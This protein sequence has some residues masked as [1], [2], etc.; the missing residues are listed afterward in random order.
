MAENVLINKCFKSS[1]KC[2]SIFRN[3]KCNMTGD[4]MCLTLCLGRKGQT[5]GPLEAA[6][7]RPCRAAWIYKG[8]DLG[9]KGKFKKLHCQVF[10]LYSRMIPALRSKKHCCL[11]EQ[12]VCFGPEMSELKSLNFTEYF[13]TNFS[14]YPW[15]FHVLCF[16]GNEVCPVF[17]SNNYFWGV[18]PISGIWMG[19]VPHFTVF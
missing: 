18:A 1:L 2:A 8:L 17:K 11:D 16:L 12:K 6:V 5:S 15:N 19:V 14:S 4:F 7:H 10:W 9:P 13:S 3:I